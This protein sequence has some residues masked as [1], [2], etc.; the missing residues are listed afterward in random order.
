M[1]KP[2]TKLRLKNAQAY[3][4]MITLDLC[5]CLKSNTKANL[6]AIILWV[7]R[8]KQRCSALWMRTQ[9]LLY[10]LFGHQIAMV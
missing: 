9:C 1:C 4:L 2:H 10:K 8:R 3:S 7:H 6:L 5:K